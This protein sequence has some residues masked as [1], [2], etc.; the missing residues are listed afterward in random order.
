VNS[1]VMVT[2][3]LAIGASLAVAGVSANQKAAQPN[4]ARLTWSAFTCAT[5]AELHGNTREQER[6]FGVGLN[7]ARVFVG[8]VKDQTLPEA[9]RREIPIGI[10]LLL[11]GPSVDFVVGRIYEGA[12]GSAYDDVVK[13]DASGL[14]ILDPRQW[15]DGELKVSKAQRKYREANCEIIR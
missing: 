7:A 9:E 14:P 15:A 3:V 2:F 1:R 13:E 8:R 4:A 10:L 11:G 5:Y 12:M 6:L